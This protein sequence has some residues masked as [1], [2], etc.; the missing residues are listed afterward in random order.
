MEIL[1]DIRLPVPPLA[2]QDAILAFIATR[3]RG[4]DVRVFEVQRAIALMHERR[5]ALISA[6]VIGQIDVRATAE[7][8]A[9]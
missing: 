1:G 8:S 2:E 9:A 4:V 5:R 7:R 3:S 6:A